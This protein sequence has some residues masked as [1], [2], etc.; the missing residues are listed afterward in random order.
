M[1]APAVRIQW[2]SVERF[3]ILKAAVLD[4]A[5][6]A[7]AAAAN[8]AAPEPPRGTLAQEGLAY[9]IPRLWAPLFSPSFLPS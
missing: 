4:V 2:T 1:K 3:P 9:S 8:R 7:A 6:R 5:A